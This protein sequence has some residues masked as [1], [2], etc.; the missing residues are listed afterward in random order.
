MHLYKY[1]KAGLRPA[2]ISPSGMADAAQTVWTLR[3]ILYPSV[4]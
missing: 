3:I 4:F 1:K 2:A